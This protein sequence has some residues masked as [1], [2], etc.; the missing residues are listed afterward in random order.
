MVLESER[1]NWTRQV[2]E[3]ENALS[4]ALWKKDDSNR[5]YSASQNRISSSLHI[6]K[7][8]AVD[9]RRS[10]DVSMLSYNSLARHEVID[11][12]ERP[13]DI[14]TLPRYLQEEVMF[15]ALKSSGKKMSFFKPSISPSAST[16]NHHAYA[17]KSLASSLSTNSTL[18]FSGGPGYS[19]L[20]G[21]SSEVSSACHS[22]THSIRSSHSS[23][24]LSATCLNRV[25][26]SSPYLHLR[27]SAFK[28]YTPSGAPG[29]RYHQEIAPG[30]EKYP[31][32]MG[33][34]SSAPGLIFGDDFDQHSIKSM[35]TIGMF[36][37]KPGWFTNCVLFNGFF[38]YL[39]IYLF[40]Y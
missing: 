26:S 39:Y 10:E 27:G 15:P 35:S 29:Y 18:L 11:F 34:S 16:S 19:S 6:K 13:K 32:T 17:R 3:S 4:S 25:R 7:S 14:P 8:N 1:Q 36:S 40:I 38:F 24:D 30:T 23:Q 5:G 33:R 21:S 20:S 2:Q 9:I 12:L 31:S 28:G 22:P 37:T